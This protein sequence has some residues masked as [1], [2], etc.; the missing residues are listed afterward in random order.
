MS[1]LPDPPPEDAEASTVPATTRLPWG[2][3]LVPLAV[4]SA[5]MM[6]MLDATA[7]ST[8]L[9]TLAREF[10]V[11]PVHLKFALTSYIMALAVAAPA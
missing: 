4:A 9:P 1:D 5:L 2:V 6:E 11:E 7:L 10:M 8:A 3:R